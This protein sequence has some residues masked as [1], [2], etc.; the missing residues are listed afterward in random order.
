[1]PAIRRMHD[2]YVEYFYQDQMRCRPTW[3]AVAA[4]E[5]AR[6]LAQRRMKKVSHNDAVA[7]DRI[8]T[9]VAQTPGWDQRKGDLLQG[10]FCLMGAD[11]SWKIEDLYALWCNVLARHD[12]VMISVTTPPRIFAERIVMKRSAEE[13]AC[14]DAFGQEDL[15]NVFFPE[16]E[17]GECNG[18][19]YEEYVRKHLHRGQ[20]FRL[21][22]ASLENL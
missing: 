15:M 4:R 20:V 7:C 5:Y 8:L 14:F 16:K 10:V 3:C 17:G 19:A 21:T 13:Q 11:E 6:D 9:V 2:F 12:S 18:E 22:I 1:M